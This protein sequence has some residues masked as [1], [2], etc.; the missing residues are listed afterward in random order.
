MFAGERENETAIAVPK[1]RRV[2]CSA[3]NVQGRNGSCCVSC[4]HNASN[5]ISSVAF[6]IAGT[7]F[8]PTRGSAASSFIVLSLKH[9][10]H[11]DHQGFKTNSLVLFVAFVFNHLVDT[12]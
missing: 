1:L 12:P 10:G 11:E 7:S 9:E 5:P 6:A 3:I 2:V 8:N 4:V